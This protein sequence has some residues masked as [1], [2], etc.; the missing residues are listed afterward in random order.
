MPG[1]FSLYKMDELRAKY[2]DLLVMDPMYNV[3]PT[4]K[5]PLI[6]NESK[7]KLLIGK[8]GLIPHWVKDDSMALSMVNAR[9]ETIDSK[10]AYK[11]L[12]RE[13]RC[14]VPCDG[15]YE[16]QEKGGKKVPFRIE[17]KD[18]KL[19]SLAGLWDIWFTEEKKV[20]TFTV[21]T[22]EPNDLVSEVHDRMPVILDSESEKKWLEEGGKDLLVPCDSD[23]LVKYQINSKVNDTKNND[24]SVLDRVSTLDMF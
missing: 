15:Y 17:R 10:P 14:I 19:F 7:G 4:M 21:I 9:A 8:W 22:C 2:S 23:L 16:W 6:T 5:V 20:L 13:Q 18:K 11:H 3:S 1:R 24:K 12:F